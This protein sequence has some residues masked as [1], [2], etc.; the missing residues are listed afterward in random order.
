M[1]AELRQ[2]YE[3]IIAKSEQVKALD[4]EIKALKAR[5]VEYHKGEKLI[6]EDGFESMIKHTVRDT[7]QLK[8]INEKY[9][10]ALS[11]DNDPDCFKRSEYDSVT[12]R[13]LIVEG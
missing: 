6:V 2:V 11:F 12:V 13:R 5:V 10:L 7:P 1:T 3:D 9:N 8:A 4:A